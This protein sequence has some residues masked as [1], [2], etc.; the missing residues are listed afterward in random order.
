MTAL[1]GCPII[2]TDTN[3]QYYCVHRHLNNALHNNAHFLIRTPSLTRIASNG[4]IFSSLEFRDLQKRTRRS[5]KKTWKDYLS[6][7]WLR[8]EKAK[9]MPLSKLYTDLVWTKNVR[10]IRDRSKKMKSMYEIIQVDGAGEEPKNVLVEGKQ[11]EMHYFGLF[12][13]IV[14]AK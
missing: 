10:G 1:F 12:I 6:N 4:E 8:P 9:K 5:I 2:Y 3:S 7:D 11:N 14:I 13:W